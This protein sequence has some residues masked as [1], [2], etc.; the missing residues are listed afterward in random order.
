[1]TYSLIAKD[2]ETGAIGVIVASRFFACGARVPCVGPRSA[3]ASQ[4]FSN[5]VW[6]TEGLR[7]LEVGERAQDVIDD[8][9]QRDTGRAARQAHMM[10][11][12]GNFAA[13]TGTE[14]VDWAGHRIGQ[15][16]SVAGNMLTGQG[17]VDATF[18]TYAAETALPFPERLL[19]A[20][21]AGERAG[22]DKRGRQAAGMVIHQGQSHSWLDLRADDHAD[23][24]AELRRLY[25]V[26]GE[27][28]LHFARAMP[29]EQN[30]SGNPDR[31]ALEAAI[32]RSD[33]H[34]QAEG[35]GSRSFATDPA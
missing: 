20:M 27:R 8:L 10:D 17:V 23:P 6:G 1:M 9:V 29:S 24:L 28:Y 18:E 2:P 5:P 35:R 25:D 22:G 7:R 11:A 19:A 26:A 16:H 32:A 33:A 31:V 13:F 30:F 4:A 14:C 15:T 3:V 12:N 34:R 21:E